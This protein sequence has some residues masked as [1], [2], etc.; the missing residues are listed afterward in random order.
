MT[1]LNTG[2]RRR[3]IVGGIVKNQWVIVQ[4]SGARFSNDHNDQQVYLN[5]AVVDP[6]LAVYFDILNEG[7]NPNHPLNGR[8]GE[9]ISVAHA[10]V[11]PAAGAGT[12]ET[13]TEAARGRKIVWANS[14]GKTVAEWDSRTGKVVVQGVRLA[15]CADAAQARLDVEQALQSEPPPAESASGTRI[16]AG[17]GQIVDGATPRAI[18]TLALDARLLR[19]SIWM[20]FSANQALY[21]DGVVYRQSA[22]RWYA[23]DGSGWIDEGTDDPEGSSVSANGTRITSSGGG[24]IV[25]LDHATWTFVGSNV[26]RIGA[27]WNGGSGSEMVLTDVPTGAREI[28]VKSGNGT[29]YR[30]N[31]V[32]DYWVGAGTNDPHTGSTPPPPPGGVTRTTGTI[33]GGQLNKINV[34]SHAIF[35]DELL[36]ANLCGVIVELGGEAPFNGRAGGERGTKGVGG[37]WPAVSFPGA[38]PDNQIGNYS[39][40]AHVWREDTGM[41][42][43]KETAGASSWTLKEPWAGGQWRTAMAIP[44]ALT[45]KGVSIVRN[46]DGTGVLTIDRNATV[47]TT[48]ANVYLDGAVIWQNALVNAPDGTNSADPG[49]DLLESTDPEAMPYNEATI[50]YSELN[51]NTVFPGLDEI[52]WGGLCKDTKRW[53]KATCDSKGSFRF[54][55][56]KGAPD[57]GMEFSTGS[58]GCVWERIAVVGNYGPV[59]FGFSQPGTTGLVGHFGFPGDVISSGFGQYNHAL[60]SILSAGIVHRD[61]DITDVHSLPAGGYF[62]G[63]LR[64]FRIRHF[65]TRASTEYEWKLQ[66][67]VCDNTAQVDCEYDSDHVAGAWEMFV[68][69]R[70]H[71]IRPKGR[72]GIWAMN[73]CGNGCDVGANPA[74]LAAGGGEVHFT[75]N[76]LVDTHNFPGSIFIGK[77][78]QAGIVVA[79]A[80]SSNAATVGAGGYSVQVRNMRVFI[81]GFQNP[82]GDTLMGFVWGAGCNDGRFVGNKYFGMPTMVPGSYT[83]GAR[84][85]NGGAARLFIQGNEIRGLSARSGNAFNIF[86]NSGAIDGGGNV[87]DDPGGP[88]IF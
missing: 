61:Y 2:M 41:V 30:A 62:G 13:I 44:F 47:P 60:Y 54:F 8:L 69:T 82:A 42:Y 38:P 81:D 67:Q 3:D 64:A 68:S 29:W 10:A 19:N 37:H 43:F 11:A 33:V 28:Y 58:K 25:A 16:T 23:F 65:Q 9:F 50:S 87:V 48:N 79:A 15:D 85:L 59:G 22:G 76:S 49:G 5:G 71:I 80:G 17:S 74:N 45:A 55:V 24:S 12:L 35:T 84:G 77:S 6:L 36:A 53:F 52:A 46:G 56:P 31:V 26:H 34:A 32:G 57:F 21:L 39:Q 7:A 66:Y 4:P 40:W 27:W 78:S 72:N 83:L 14:V 1:W 86:A 18:W 63:G 70:A 20:G 88:V 51:A 73:N 75:A